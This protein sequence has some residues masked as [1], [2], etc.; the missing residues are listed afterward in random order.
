MERS[1]TVVGHSSSDFLLTEVVFP[2]FGTEQ[3]ERNSY[4]STNRRSQLMEEVMKDDA[5]FFS[6]ILHSSQRNEY[7]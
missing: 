2:L 6:C 7:E 1:G 4:A 3:P 5:S